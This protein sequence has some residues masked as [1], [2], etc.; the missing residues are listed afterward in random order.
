MSSL[1]DILTDHYNRHGEIQPR[2]LWQEARPQGAPLH[3]HFDWNNKTAGDN[4]RDIQ[5]AQLIRSC[6]IAFTDPAEPAERRYV[7][8]FSSVRQNVDPDKTGY[9]PTEEIAADPLAAKILLREAERE[10]KE[11]QRKYGH[12]KGFIEMIQSGFGDMTA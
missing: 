1:R 8:A 3:H 5:A 11:F 10:W 12:L 6:R 7:R 4:Y 2:R 9:R